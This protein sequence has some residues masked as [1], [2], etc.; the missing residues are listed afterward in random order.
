MEVDDKVLVDCD[1]Q[2][3]VLFVE[4]LENQLNINQP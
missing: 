3:L 1:L 2:A 4:S